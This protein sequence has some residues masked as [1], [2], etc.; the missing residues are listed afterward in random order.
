MDLQ[1]R[2]REA[3]RI[4]LG[5]QVPTKDGKRRP[6]KL[7]HFRFTSR[8]QQMIERVAALYGGQWRPWDNGGKP[9]FEVQT[10]ATQIP[11]CVP[12]SMSFSQA[13]EVWG[14]GFCTQRCDGQWDGVRDCP[15]DCDPDGRVCKITTRLSLILPEVGGIG[16][17][18]LESHGYYSA[19][20]LAG[21]I[22]V[23]EAAAGAGIA[24]PAEL[25][26]DQREVRRLVAGKPQT[27][28]FV[29]PTLDVDLPALM[30]G[31]SLQLQGAPD[32]LPG[33]APVVGPAAEATG[34][35]PVDQQALAPAPTMSV[36]DQLAD[37]ERPVTPRKGKVPVNRSGRAPRKA[38]AVDGGTC[39]L[40]HLPYGTDALVKN[41]VALGSKYVHVQCLPQGVQG[42]LIEGGNG[43]GT[44]SDSEPA[45][46]PVPVA[47]SPSGARAVSHGQHR[48]LMA[49]TNEA[50]PKIGDE[51]G[52]TLDAR[53]RDFF[54]GLAG[55]LGQ[56]VE[57]RS[58]I[59]MATFQPM[60]DALEGIRDGHL[61]LSQID[62]VWGLFDLR[63]GEQTLGWQP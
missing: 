8:S 4:R 37:N 18:R 11:V 41:P 3:G 5:E 42:T 13:Y 49:L 51:D 53:R 14:G 1:R 44:D 33:P 32:A 50:W 58:E 38:A 10:T 21:V 2:L 16:T 62:G 27:Y 40:C 61:G 22:D 60:V 15:C 46:E 19:S 54:M 57:H 25:G 23:I 39:D 55:C 12:T 31:P 56:P 24:I 20:E 7:D 30:G 36:A 9:E 59:S 35:A 45:A 29:V 43:N 47:P 17:W 52:T 26:L 6:R 63:T 48:R 34:W 28:Q